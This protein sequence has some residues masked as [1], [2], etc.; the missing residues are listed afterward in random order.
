MP[1]WLATAAFLLFG[2]VPGSV[3]LKCQVLLI[4]QMPL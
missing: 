2:L 3:W 1:L 4:G